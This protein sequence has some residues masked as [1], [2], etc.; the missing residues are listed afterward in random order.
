MQ[1][2]KEDIIDLEGE[3]MKKLEQ[4]QRSQNLQ[5]KKIAFCLQN[6]GDQLVENLAARIFGDNT[7]KIEGN[8]NNNNNM[9][10]M[11]TMS[12]N[13]RTN[14]GF[15]GLDSNFNTNFNSR[16]MSIKVNEE[17]ANEKE[18]NNESKI[19]DKQDDKN[20]TRRQSYLEFINII[21]EEKNETE[22]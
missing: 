5:M 17:E 6:S 14:F 7:I 21:P 22:K 3:L 16:R 10:Y 11:N 4:V 9:S 12:M 19:N 1:T 18:K 8:N 2:L 15:P 13:T 20:K